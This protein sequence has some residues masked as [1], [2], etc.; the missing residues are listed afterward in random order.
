MRLFTKV[1]CIVSNIV[2]RQ[3]SGSDDIGR[4]EFILQIT[5]RTIILPLAAHICAWGN[6][7]LTNQKQVLN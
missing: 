6:N 7:L 5:D 3:S 2:I 4:P 1:Y